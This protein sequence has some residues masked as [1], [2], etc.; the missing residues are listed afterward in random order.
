MRN[1]TVL[2]LLIVFYVMPASSQ[3][4]I[5]LHNLIQPLVS[6]HPDKTGLYVLE[7]GG[8]ALLAR[9]WLADRAITSID[10]Q[11]FIWGN[12]N[13]GKLAAETLLRAADRGVHVRVLVDDLLIDAESESLFSLAHHPEIEIRIYNPV[14]SVGVNFVERLAKLT[15]N[16]RGF[17]A[18]IL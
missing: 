2:I 3:E 16:F 7:K 10:V 17:I 6:S 18:L 15:L 13:I 11:Y 1:F 12:D 9:G 14:H 4:H 8:E 5:S